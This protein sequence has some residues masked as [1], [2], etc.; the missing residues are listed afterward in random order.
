MGT[1]IVNG[2][3]YD[4]PLETKYDTRPENIKVKTSQNF[5]KFDEVF[6]VKSDKVNGIFDDNSNMLISN[7]INLSKNGWAG[8]SK[9]IS[10][11]EV[12]ER[13]KSRVNVYPSIEFYNK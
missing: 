9:P 2:R 7:F 8:C 13:F 12:T 6:W 3:V 4:I 11:Y 10:Y 1:D 5:C